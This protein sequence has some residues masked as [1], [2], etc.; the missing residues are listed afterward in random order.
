MEPNCSKCKH[1]YITYDKHTPR[2]C[3]I[4]R[5]ESASFPNLVVKAANNGAKC[6]G[7]ELRKKREEKKSLNLNDPSLW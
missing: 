6:I 5:I 1:F 4:Y 7:F 3:R 2:G